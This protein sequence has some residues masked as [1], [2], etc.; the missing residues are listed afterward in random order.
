MK[1]LL[2]RF[3]FKKSVVNLTKRSSGIKSIFDKTIQELREVNQVITDQIS[4]KENL[5]KKL[6]EE[7]DVLAEVQTKN[8]NLATKIEAL[9]S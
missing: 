6:T 4:K 5:V 3:F 9:L 2:F 1:K 8:E 7:K